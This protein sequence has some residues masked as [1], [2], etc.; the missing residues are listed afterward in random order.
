MG[1]GVVRLALVLLVLVTGTVC[2][3]GQDAR[4]QSAGTPDGVTKAGTAGPVEEDDGEAA[5]GES[6]S[7]LEQ[8][9][10]LTP[11]IRCDDLLA[12]ATDEAPA[13]YVIRLNTELY[14]A[15]LQGEP[16]TA[17]SD[18][19]ELTEV[20]RE[21]LREALVNLIDVSGMYCGLVEVPEDDLALLVVD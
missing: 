5:I 18:P 11:V 3:C 6:W 16:L 17:D 14:V 4:D 12:L 1:N 8:K 21:L 15:L 19:I 7:S 20:E 10:G 2:A 13:E 9:T